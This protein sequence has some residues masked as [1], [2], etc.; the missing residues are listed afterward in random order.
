MKGLLVLASHLFGIGVIGQGSAPPPL[1]LDSCEAFWARMDAKFE[2]SLRSPLKQ[3][4]RSRFQQLDRY[5]CDATFVVEA[6]FKPIKNGKEFAMPTTTD[7]LPIYRPVGRVSFKVNGRKCSLTVFQNHDLVEKL[8][9]ENYLFL[10][11]TDPTNAFETYG[12][13]RYIDLLGPLGPTLWIDL[14][15]AYNPSCA[16]N[17]R[18]SCPI[19]PREN[20][21]DTPIKAG[22]RKYHD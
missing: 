21:L 11:F 10:P 5:P 12:G 17:E 8:G 9:F 7:R 3:E 13:G 15:R 14:N 20:H 19:P 4:D 6:R 16:Y 2:D 22:V 1:P 18:Y